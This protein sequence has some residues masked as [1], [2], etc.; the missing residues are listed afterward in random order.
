VVARYIRYIIDVVTRRFTQFFKPTL[1]T[2][3]DV[4]L[5]TDT[6]QLL[7]AS[8]RKTLVLDLDETLVHSCYIDPDSNGIVGCNF[9]PETAVPDY[10]MHIRILAEL[11]PIEFHVF[12]RPYVDEFLDFVSKW[13]DLVIY[14]AS[15]EPYA[16]SVVDKLDAGR[17]ILQRRYYRQH[18]MPASSYLGK[19]LYMV[20]KDLSRVFIIDN[21][22][23][24]Y[25]EFPQNA[26]PIKSYVYDPEDQELLNLLPF[27]DALRFTRDVRSV[28]GR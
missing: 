3:K 10:I 12:K 7:V 28:L 4:P 17:G 2:Y 25:R 15:M 18:C 13:Y 26:I 27:L 8:G 16:S 20:N 1:Y 24:A 23:S 11:A 5:S 9:V 14:T 19:D 6:R 22:P 21:S